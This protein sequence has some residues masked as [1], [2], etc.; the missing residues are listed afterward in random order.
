AGH[1]PEV[2]HPGQRHGHETIQ[3]FIHANAAQG[4]HA[5]NGLL[6]ADLETRN[7]LLGLGHHRL[8]AC[9]FGQV[10]HS[11]VHDLLVSHSFAHAHVERDLAEARHFHNGLV[12]ELLHQRWRHGVAIDVLKTCH[13]YAAL[14]SSPLDLKTRTFLP[15]ARSLMPTRSA[16]PVTP[17]KM[18]TLD[19]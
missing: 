10:A 1:T 6:F 11:A 8:L 9:N 17:L 7:G 14:I 19:W 16:L 18:A 12:A 4:H 15:S 13:V 3:E 5:T 2:T